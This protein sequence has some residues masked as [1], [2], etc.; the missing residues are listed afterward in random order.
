LL[1]VRTATPMMIF[2]KKCRQKIGHAC[3]PDSCSTYFVRITDPASG[4]GAM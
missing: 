3:W 1:E 2:P 4:T